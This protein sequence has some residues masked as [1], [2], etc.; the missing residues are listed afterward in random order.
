MTE[1]STSARGTTVFADDF[2]DFEKGL[3]RVNESPIAVATLTCRARLDA[4][5]WESMGQ[6]RVIRR[7]ATSRGTTSH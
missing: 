1:L 2:A 6:G 7:F 4:A 5:T 3:R